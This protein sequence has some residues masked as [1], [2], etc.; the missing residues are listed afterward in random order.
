M[1]INQGF[2][3]TRPDRLGAR[4]VP[5]A[6]AYFLSQRYGTDF[7]FEWRRTYDIAPPLEVLSKST[8]DK[9]FSPVVLEGNDLPIKISENQ[10]CNIVS[11]FKFPA[12]VSESSVR[13][14]HPFGVYAEEFDQK[15]HVRSEVARLFAK[16]LLS[17]QLKAA[18]EEVK[19]SIGGQY[20][21]VHLR[22]GDLAEWLKKPENFFEAFF[23]YIPIDVVEIA[24]SRSD[25][26]V[27]FTDS[28]EALPDHLKPLSVERFI[29]P[30]LAARLTTMQRDLLEM[31]ILG[32]STK[33]YAAK[34]AF[35][36]CSSLLGGASIEHPVFTLG[37][38]RF[39]DEMRSG[40]DS[41]YGE[42]CS[43]Q[44]AASLDA[45]ARKLSQHG[46]FDEADQVVRYFLQHFPSDAR[47]HLRAGHLQ[48]YKRG[49]SDGAEA[50][51]RSISIDTSADAYAGL[52][53]SLHG[54][55][56][57]GERDSALTQAVSLF[58]NDKNLQRLQQQYS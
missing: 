52:V 37:V 33:I 49:F 38:E 44:V 13:V 21:S 25:A 10:V 54:M 56:L 51:K 6:N 53:R 5:I 34:S 30:A 17:D 20:A 41:Y 22:R 39:F 35:S 26:L 18:Y 3:A 36:S 50:F 40:K 45:G 28:V 48:L 43:E 9:H 11:R 42:F 24:K 57:L 55:R 14:N 1:P 4:L 46:Q 58:P 23:R 8:V 27:I 29:A 47:A 15:D 32:G 12:T 2:I 7:R 16:D 19:R 31:L